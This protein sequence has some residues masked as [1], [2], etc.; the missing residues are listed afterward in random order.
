MAQMDAFVPVPA[1]QY[2]VLYPPGTLY[3]TEGSGGPESYSGVEGTVI[4]ELAV[5]GI[6]R[7]GT[8]FEAPRRPVGAARRRPRLHRRHRLR[9][10]RLQPPRVRGQLDCLDAPDLVGLNRV[11]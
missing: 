10:R 3:D 2:G 6:G 1:G 4:R 8:V 7:N 11:H 5:S 9:R